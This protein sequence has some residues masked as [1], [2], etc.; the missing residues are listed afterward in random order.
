MWIFPSSSVAHLLIPDYFP[1]SQAS[2]EGR[3]GR[4]KGYWRG[5]PKLTFR[6]GQR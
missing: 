1:G 5:L 4:T 3:R 6:I 2:G